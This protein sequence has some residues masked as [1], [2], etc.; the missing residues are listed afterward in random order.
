MLFMTLVRWEAARLA[1]EALARVVGFDAEPTTAERT[2]GQHYRNGLGAL[3]SFTSGVVVHGNPIASG[4]NAAHDPARSELNYAL[5]E[6]RKAGVVG[7]ATRF[8]RRTAPVL[9]VATCA[10]LLLQ[11]RAARR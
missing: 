4:W 11:A 8:A 3:L 6:L 9:L 10:G 5:S 2:R 1:L 7:S